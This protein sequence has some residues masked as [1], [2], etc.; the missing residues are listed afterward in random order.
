MSSKVS[1]KRISFIV[2]LIATIILLIMALLCS[3]L[4]GDA[5][6][7]FGTIMEAIFNGSYDRWIDCLDDW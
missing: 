7:D 6:I 5:K 4:I 1:K 2:Y 3:I